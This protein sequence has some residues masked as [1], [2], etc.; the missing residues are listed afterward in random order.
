MDNLNIALCQPDIVWNN[1]TANM[2]MFNQIFVDFSGNAD[3]FILP[4]MFT[5]GFLTNPHEYSLQEQENTVLW[6]KENAAKYKSAIAGSFIVSEN[7]AFFNRFMWVE[8]NGKWSI[9][10]KHHLFSLGNEDKSYSKG[11]E[12]TVFSYRGWKI[13][14]LICYDLR[15]PV[16]AR[17]SFLDNDF[18]YDLL[19]V[20]ANWPASRSFHWRQLL[21]ARAIENQC[22][23]VGANR[24]GSDENGWQYNGGSCLATPEGF[25]I[26]E[27]PNQTDDV[28]LISIDYNKLSAYRKAFPF[29]RDWDRFT[30]H[31]G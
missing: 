17:N 19:L 21:M 13:M 16:W 11:V 10:D 9:Y 5:T 14:P 29:A 12:R 4:E 2:A 1:P 18:E 27:Q 30:I 31:A 24:T 8:P 15:F 28:V 20:V 25:W 26:P 3:V 23:V 6:M 22:Y 7:D